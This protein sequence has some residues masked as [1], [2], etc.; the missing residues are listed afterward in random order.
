MYLL[1]HEGVEPAFVLVCILYGHIMPTD[2]IVSTEYPSARLGHGEA[3]PASCIANNTLQFKIATR[4]NLLMTIL[5]V[6]IVV[7]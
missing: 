6:A 7:V 4:E 5:S 2:N 1:I 3:F